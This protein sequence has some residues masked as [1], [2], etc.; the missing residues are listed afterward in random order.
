M[1][2]TFP[3]VFLVIVAVLFGPAH[4][5]RAQS[6]FRQA[7]SLSV[8]GD[9]KAILTADLNLDGHDDVAVPNHLGHTVSIFHG[10]GTGDL[11]LS[12][13]L[14]PGGN[15]P[16]HL[17]A[18]DFDEDGFPDLAVADFSS[19]NAVRILLNLGD[20]RFVHTS[21][22]PAGQFPRA[23]V[24]NDLN[25][26]GHLDIAVAN[27]N[28]G[29]ISLLIGDGGGGFSPINS[30]PTGNELRNII[31]D[32][33]DHDGDLDLA[34][35][36]RGTFGLSV[37]LNDGNGASY[38]TTTHP[39]A[40][41]AH[42]LTS[43]D[44]DQDGNL[45]II[46]GATV[47]E[48][49]FSIYI[50]R[51]LGDGQ[52]SRTQNLIGPGGGNITAEDLDGDEILDLVVLTGNNALAVFH[53]EQGGGYAPPQMIPS[54]EPPSAIGVGDFDE[55]GDRDLVVAS[56][57]SN[58]GAISIFFNNAD[59]LLRSR[60]GTVNSGVGNAN[61][62][63][64]VNGSAGAGQDRVVFVSPDEPIVYTMISPPSRQGFRSKYLAYE[65]SLPLFCELRTLPF[66]VGTTY[67]PTP[68]T[69]SDPESSFYPEKIWNTFGFFRV[70]GFP[71]HSSQRAPTDFHSY[72]NGLG[73]ESVFI[74]GLVADFGGVGQVSVSVTNGVTVVADP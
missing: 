14:T 4:P 38:L 6:C 8:G 72:P 18:G 37:H 48:E 35:V 50:F 9:P 1:L 43:S 36:D 29:T 12:Q 7:Q 39:L 52:F 34:T 51:G 49:P 44:L 66:E 21:S 41:L 24:A 53:G 55:D 74:Q 68:I 73:L 33:F 45:D 15:R 63:L 17:T 58:N 19:S 40:N 60:R 31:S 3:S 62:V 2:Q 30:Y 71:T 54:S 20:G 23:V 59:E 16:V 26:D 70:A 32:D 27:R 46:V 28:G 13:V 11:Q 10:D 69:D 56:N 42:S 57:S 5:A 64:F 25:G 61:D 67:L 65:W 47:N 22:V